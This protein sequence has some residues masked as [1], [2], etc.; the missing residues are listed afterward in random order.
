MFVCSIYKGVMAKRNVFESWYNF[1]LF[2]ISAHFFIN[3]T[4]IRYLCLHI[5]FFLAQV[6]S[7]QIREKVTQKCKKNDSQTGN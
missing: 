4:F 3:I 5:I 2:E 7:L 1:T 6:C